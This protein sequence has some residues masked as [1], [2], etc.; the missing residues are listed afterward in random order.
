MAY[1]EELLLP[2]MI[3]HYRE[4]FPNC[5]IVVYDNESIDATE[6]I[7]ISNN[8]EVRKYCTNNQ[9]DDDKL[10]NLKNNC[11]KTA[12]T[13]WVLVCDVDEWLDINETDLKKED[14]SGTLIIRSEAY[15]MVNMEDNLDIPN[16]KY[17]WRNQAYDKMF[18]FNKK[19]IKEINYCHGAHLCQP[20]SI[21][22]IK[23]SET[24]YK[25]YHCHYINIELSVQRHKMT[26]S[27]M[28]EKNLKNGWGVIH[29]DP[30]GD[31]R[32]IF[33]GHQ[34]NATKIRQ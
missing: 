27:R 23:Y 25:L 19:Y 22:P 34:Q 8:C 4:R 3:N 14:S 28:S 29:P 20:I 30:E 26:M 7:A 24:P 11:W 5:H 12:T 9:I 31:I 17:G 33:I 21:K 16:I 32:K 2:H 6:K 10:R 18:L 13:D 1:N 15:N